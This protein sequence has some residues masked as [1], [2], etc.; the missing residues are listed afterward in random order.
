MRLGLGHIKIFIDNYYDCLAL[1]DIELSTALGKEVK[2]DMEVVKYKAELK[3]YAD[4]EISLNPM[5]LV[6]LGKD[7][8]GKAKRFLFQASEVER[9]TVA[10]YTNFIVHMN[11]SK[12]KNEGDKAKLKKVM[13]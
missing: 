13:S 6:F 7:K 4:G 8:K 9:Y 12:K 11:N 2:V 1:T 3:K 10:Q 5:G